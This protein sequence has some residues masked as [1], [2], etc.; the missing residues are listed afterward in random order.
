[1]GELSRGQ[2]AQGTIVW[3]IIVRGTITQRGIVRGVIG[4]GGNCPEGMV[5]G[6][7]SWRVIVQTQWSRG[8][9][10]LESKFITAKVSQNLKFCKLCQHT[11]IN[12]IVGTYFQK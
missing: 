9:I 10:V 11:E 5:L 12:N 6:A 3:G 1:M 7:I 2:L 8:G 4:M